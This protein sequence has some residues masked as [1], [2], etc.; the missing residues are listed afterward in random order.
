[1]P[2]ENVTWKINGARE[3]DELLGELPSK[4]Q[5]KAMRGAVGAGAKVI[6]DDARTRVD[7]K[8]GDLVAGI[9]YTT[10]V[11]AANGQSTAK[12]FVSQKK[13]WYGRLVESGTKPHIIKAR[14]AKALKL[15][16]GRLVEQVKHPGAKPKPFMR[17]AAETKYPQAVDAMAA[18][19][20]TFFDH[21]KG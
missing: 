18:K 21:L 1:M 13:A 2:S 19:L 12:V 11:D 5:A 16:G 14:N 4:L 6:R 3:L 10:R 9:R 8:S 20:T 17:P 15:H 7:S